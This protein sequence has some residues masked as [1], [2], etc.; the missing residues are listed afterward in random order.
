M[1][2]YRINARSIYADIK[3]QIFDG[4][5][6]AGASMPSTRALA[7]QLG[8]ARTT[9]VTAYEQLL[10]EGLIETRPGASTRVAPIHPPAN[11]KDSNLKVASPRLSEYGLRVERVPPRYGQRPDDLLV[12]FRYGD[13]AGA[14]F[15]TQSWRRA[16]NLA[17]SQNFEK[18][19][20]ADPRGS[21][22]LRKALQAHLWRNRG[23]RCH[24]DQL[25][26]VNGSQQ[27]LDLCARLLLNPKDR[28]VIEE[29]CYA[30]ARHLFM[31]VGAQSVPIAVDGSGLDTRQLREVEAKLA[32]V[33]PSHQFPRGGVMP[34]ARRQEL[35]EWSEANDAYIVED[36]YDGEYRYD[37]KPVP[38][39]ITLTAARRILYL[40]TISKTLSP[41][42]RLGYLLVPEELSG[43]F[44]TAK[45]LLDRHT[46][47]LQQEALTTLLQ[48]GAYERHARRMRRRNGER[49][50]ALLQ[51]LT[52]ILGDQVE[53]EGSDAGLHL[54]LWL[55]NVPASVE[56][57]LLE[58]ARR[59]GLG[60]HSVRPLYYQSAPACVGLVLGYAGLD[61]QQIA[62][63]V[64][65]LGE[66]LQA[67]NWQS[68]GTTRS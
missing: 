63:G 15:P 26:I 43:V 10:C 45:E 28:F 56:G 32:Y 40:G 65:L 67:S 41:L 31:S 6:P 21:L 38:P 66:V 3:A 22:P 60:L 35:L 62:Q 50:T 34:L 55:R 48:N 27:G 36:D 2:K 11:K 13:L 25:I 8:V 39:L 30:M 19:A 16:V 42:L 14:D 29:P 52:Q 46:P 49:R 5:Y 68:V 44:S 23:I 33:T 54:L 57:R 4:T 20:Y 37:I 18:I 64:E 7:L 17:A 1:K 47:T 59:S 12:D 58:L 9:V 61:L 53:V 51:N 24:A